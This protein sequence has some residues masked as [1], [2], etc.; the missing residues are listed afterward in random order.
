M[1]Q[2]FEMTDL[3]EMYFLGKEIKQHN[4]EVFIYQKKYAKD[5]LKKLK[6]KNCKATTTPMCQM[7]KLSK[8]DEAEKVD[9]TLYRSL[10][11]CL[12][13]LTTTTLDILYVVSLLSRF[14]NCA[15]A[16]HF[17]AA[18]R[19]IKICQGDIEFWNQVLC[20]LEVRV[21]GVF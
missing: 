20:K 5:I 14:S 4:N 15:T 7:E 17:K 18:K 12:M 8:N 11:G 9:E 13:Y 16:T 3:G 1:Q 19:V 21:A 10:V 2:T 6:M